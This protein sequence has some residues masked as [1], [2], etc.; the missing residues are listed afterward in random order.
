MLHS[1]CCTVPP[2]LSKPDNTPCT[3]SQQGRPSAL[4]GSRNSRGHSAHGPALE[5]I[6]TMSCGLFLHLMRAGR[7]GVSLVRCRNKQR[8]FFYPITERRIFELVGL[9]TRFLL[10]ACV[11]RISIIS[12]YLEALQTRHAL[13]FRILVNTMYMHYFLKF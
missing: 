10:T 6:S 1:N 2:L 13:N 9:P 5:A 11:P 7:G 3:C 12:P 4:R 8:R